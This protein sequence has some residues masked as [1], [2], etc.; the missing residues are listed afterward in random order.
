MMLFL[1]VVEKMINSFEITNETKN[2]SLYTPKPPA[3][4]GLKEKLQEDDAKIY[5]ARSGS[6]EPFFIHM[7]CF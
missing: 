6:M 5:V 7:I 3:Y 4:Q 1:P 2:L